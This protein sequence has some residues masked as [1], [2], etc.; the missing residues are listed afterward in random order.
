MSGT[1]SIQATD[2]NSA[3]K[4]FAPPETIDEV[5]SLLD[6]IPA[7]DYGVWFE[8]AC[9][10]KH[11]GIPYQVFRDWSATSD[12]FDEDECTQKW[13]DLPDEPRAGW[14][15]LRKYAGMASFVPVPDQMLPEPQT[16]DE[17]AAQAAHYL[18]TRFKPGERFELCGWRPDPHKEN[19]LI[20]DRHLPLPYLEDSDTEN[21]LSQDEAVRMWVR[22]GIL[23][24]VV[25]SQNPLDVP[26]DYKGYAPTD[27]MVSRYD[28]ALL[29]GDEIPVEEQW[30]KLKQMRLP[31]VSVVKSAGKS[32]HI[33]CRVDAGPDGELYKERVNML[34][35]YVRPFGF[36]PDE[37]C[38]NASRL[39]RLPGAMRD[40][41]RQ[42][43]VCGP[44]GYPDWESFEMCELKSASAGNKNQAARDNKKSVT[45][46]SHIDVSAS[47]IIQEEKALLDGL[48]KE[49]SA[50][51]TFSSKGMV[52]GVNEAFWAAYVM[53]TLGLIKVS[54]IIWRYASMSGL[55]L[56]V[57]A[58]ELNNLI[59]KTA[60]DYSA[61]CGV[62]ELVTK[63]NEPT[64]NHIRKFMK[65]AEKDLFKDR[66]RNLIHVGNGMV[67][68]NDDGTCILKPF[69]P[70]YYSRNQCNIEYN[71]NAQCPRFLSELLEPMLPEN[72]I[73]TLQLY[74]GQCLLG[75]NLYQ[76]FL[77]L[78]GTPGGGKGTLVN[79]IRSIV[80]EAN[81]VE[82]RT[83]HLGE[84]FELARF[85]GKTLLIGS[86]VPSDFLLKK[87]AG[88]VKSLCGW[89]LLS[90]EVK[91]LTE[92]VPLIGNFNMIITAND[93]LL[94]R[95]DGDIGAWKRRIIW[96]PY[97][98][99]ETSN[100]ISDFS[101]VLL[102]KE[103]P[104]I[105]NWMIQGAAKLLQ[106]GFPSESLSSVRVERL[107]QE[108]NS[109]Y[110]FLTTCIEKVD[111]GVGITIGEL[112]EK[113]TNWCQANDWDPLRGPAGRHKLTMNL[114]SLF[115]ISQAH[116][117]VRKN[118]AG[119]ETALRG[120]H[121]VAFKADAS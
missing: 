69:S 34:F 64:C 54:G 75:I 78:T 71:P 110:Y 94:V 23:N 16:E 21:S 50:P 72:D 102:H 108:S 1:P 86:D 59:A 49:F 3:P 7:D 13:E 90:A 85:I 62:G 79:I 36:I 4:S 103:G 29:E 104:G 66:T 74:C 58:E 118:M 82:L 105:L 76:K 65:D 113:Y 17:C 120:Y 98:K 24:G 31:V 68:I 51:L 117:I 97:E 80:G 83:E 26:P 40:G 57:S 93:R 33:E 25:V 87:S 48:E 38:K 114:E 73:E 121:G 15:T 43:L 41:K 112:E 70:D 60:R 44:C 67:E 37:K 2:A 47:S 19:H 11:L 9:A 89:D 22:D 5:Q 32:L 30:A 20:P 52:I 111:F 8:V 18:A 116:D 14:P 28:F 35:E 84:R 63:F 107:L 115:H 109:I 12:K 6:Q 10:V 39:T 92:S 56:R 81:S 100:P 46:D 101:G 77:L 55:W 96:I 61:T 106:H 95:L 53:R 91:G 27:A 99:H 119:D 88:K 45:H 42:Y